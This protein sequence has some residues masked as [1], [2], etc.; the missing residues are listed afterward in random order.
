MSIIRNDKLIILLVG[1][2]K[3]L[4]DRINP[5]IFVSNCENIKASHCQSC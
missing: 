2:V 4:S 1:S 5:F 3:M